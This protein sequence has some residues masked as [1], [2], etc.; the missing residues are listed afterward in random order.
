MQ[1]YLKDYILN[2][3]NW[4]KAFEAKYMAKNFVISQEHKKYDKSNMKH[5]ND[6]SVKNQQEFKFLIVF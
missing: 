6:T 4:Q 5:K 1:I 2:S 3:F